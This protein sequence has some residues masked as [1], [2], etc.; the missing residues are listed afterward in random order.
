[1][2]SFCVVD[3]ET[4]LLAVP[5]FRPIETESYSDQTVLRHLIDLRH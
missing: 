3:E 5:G 1:M 2:L 4:V